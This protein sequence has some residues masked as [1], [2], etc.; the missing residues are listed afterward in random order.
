M[1]FDMPI[2]FFL[3]TFPKPKSIKVYIE[4]NAAAIPSNTVPAI[5]SRVA[6]I[7]HTAIFLIIHPPHSQLFIMEDV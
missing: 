3:G 6:N 7:N 1:V 4:K 5:P 2:T